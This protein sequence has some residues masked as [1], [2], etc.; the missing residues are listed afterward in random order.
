[1]SVKIRIFLLERARQLVKD[2]QTPIRRELRTGA[3]ARVLGEAKRLT[4]QILQPLGT[5]PPDVVPQHELVEGDLFGFW[6]P[7]PQQ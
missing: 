3:E 1:M 5:R 4:V 2:R 6:A 7:V